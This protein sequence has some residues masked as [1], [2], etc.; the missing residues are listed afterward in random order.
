[1]APEHP[2]S[3]GWAQASF[4]ASSEACAEAWDTAWETLRMVHDL[5]VETARQ[6]LEHLSR[7]WRNVAEQ[8]ERIWG[9]Y[10]HAAQEIALL[11]DGPAAVHAGYEGDRAL[12]KAHASAE[13]SRAAPKVV[14]EH[15]IESMFRRGQLQPGW[16]FLFDWYHEL[17]ETAEGGSTGV[18][19]LD[20]IVVSHGVVPQFKTR[21]LQAI[22]DLE[23][24][25]REP[26]RRRAGAKAEEV[27]DVTHRF[28]RHI[29]SVMSVSQLGA[30]GRYGKRKVVGQLLKRA[31]Q[32]LADEHGVTAAR[33]RARYRRD[34]D[35]VPVA[36]I[37]APLSE[38]ERAAIEA[39][40]AAEREAA[41]AAEA[42]RFQ[43]GKAH[44][45]DLQRQ[46]RAG[47]R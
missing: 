22:H 11:E 31:Y 44:A 21:R 17:S 47:S 27:F 7:L 4:E 15:P 1:M 26:I 28:G 23:R 24:E 40:A 33:A 32:A 37:V 46:R 10:L 18:V 41:R 5:Q 36:G 35:A 45:M 42:A 2:G 14:R 19:N 12:A 25:F 43:Q 16:R 30:D 3:G 6:R 13:A 34:G 9:Q 38:E 8:R 39:H 20:A 29:N